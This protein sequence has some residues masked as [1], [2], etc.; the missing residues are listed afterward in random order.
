VIINPLLKLNGNKV[1]IKNKENFNEIFSL[2]LQEAI[3]SIGAKKGS[4][5]FPDENGILQS[6]N[7]NILPLTEKI[8]ITSFAERKNFLV[9]KQDNF[10]NENVPESYL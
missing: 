8:A 2:I 1:Y 3:K 9:K 7:K 5:F 6:T 4:L 10:S